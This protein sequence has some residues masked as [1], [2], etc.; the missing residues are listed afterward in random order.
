[1]EN[2]ELYAVWPFN[3]VS[4]GHPKLLAEAK[5]AYQNRKNHLDTGWGYDGNVAALLGMT[6]EAGRILN[7]KVRNSH[8]AYRWPATW[9]PNFDW[10]P[11]QNHGGNLLNTTHLML[12]QAD[13][14][15]AGG[16]IRVLPA[17]PKDWDVSFKLHAPGDTIVECVFEKGTIKF[18]K[19]SPATRRVDLVLPD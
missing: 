7:V 4:V 16:A 18:L 10:L 1:M 2:G 15:E 14:L 8:P 3:L 13:P 19:I 6:N 11:D 9:G 5:V 17:W 12:L